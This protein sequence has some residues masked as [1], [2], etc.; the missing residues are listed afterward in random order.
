MAQENGHNARWQV[1]S[2][3]NRK[4]AQSAKAGMGSWVSEQGVGGVHPREIPELPKDQAAPGQ[5]GDLRR[6]PTNT[7]SVQRN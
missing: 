2:C 7:Q 1:H 6:H 5:E 4:D 3:R